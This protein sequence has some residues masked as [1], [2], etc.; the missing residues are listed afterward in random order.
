M[1]SKS[2]SRRGV[3]KGIYLHVINKVIDGAAEAVTA[4]ESP[5][6]VQDW[7]HR[8]P[9]PPCAWAEIPPAL[10]KSLAEE[11]G[12]EAEKEAT[13]IFSSLAFTDLKRAFQAKPRLFSMKMER[14]WTLPVGVWDLAPGS[15]WL[16][17][18][19]LQV[20]ILGRMALKSFA[21]YTEKGVG[22]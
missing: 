6:S 2:T 22:R 16:W 18:R 19:A 1:Q 13:G 15:A 17:A 5:R 8:A 11:C 10:R 4:L 7:E 12:W 14:L 21:L 9:Q 20:L 3:L